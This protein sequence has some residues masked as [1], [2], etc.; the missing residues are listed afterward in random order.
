MSG[1]FFPEMGND[2]LPG[3][4]TPVEQEV[5]EFLKDNQHLKS[6]GIV[7]DAAS[8]DPGHTGRTTVLRAGT[9][10]MKGAATNGKYVPAGHANA[11]ASNAITGAV[12][13]EKFVDMRSKDPNV[14]ADKSGRGVIHGFVDD[15]KLFYVD[16]AYKSALQAALPL[17]AFL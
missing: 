4:S 8:V 6:I 10:L 11:P 16:N 9:L 3:I 12:I 17:V 1:D 7:I 13:L 14:T 5:N 2:A 15:S